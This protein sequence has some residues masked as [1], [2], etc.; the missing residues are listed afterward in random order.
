M[1]NRINDA[2][3][4]VKE[5]RLVGANVEQGVYSYEQAMRIADDQ[6][7]DLVEISAN[8]VPPVCRILDYQK[9]L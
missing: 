8:A 6:N 2:I 9:F 5:V 7:L 3:R 1:P 4:G